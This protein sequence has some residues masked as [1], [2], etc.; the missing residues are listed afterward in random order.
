MCNKFDIIG[1]PS[2]NAKNTI[3]IPILILLRRLFE[4][5]FWTASFKIE[6]AH[7]KKI[8]MASIRITKYKTLKI[9]IKYSAGLVKLA[10]S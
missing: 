3:P 5:F 10:R 2:A 9:P 6:T 4:Y 7:I 1:D 8:A